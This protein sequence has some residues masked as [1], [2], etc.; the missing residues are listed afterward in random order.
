MTNFSD[1]GSVDGLIGLWDFRS[2]A[3]NKD[4]GLDDGVAQNGHFHGDAYASS[5]QLKLDGHCDYFDVSGNDA[6]FDLSEGTIE[7][8]FQQ[9][10]QVGSSPD[11]LVNRGEYNDK[12][13]EG[14]FA[15]RVTEHGEVLVDHYTKD[16]TV[17]TL[18]TD[19]GLV[20]PHDVINVSYSWDADTGAT[21]TVENL[22]DGTSQTVESDVTGLTMDIGDNDDENFTFGA[23]E[24]DDGKYDQ[25]FDGK[26]DYVAIYDSVQGEGDFIVEGTSGDDLIDVAYTGDPENDSI[27]AGDNQTGGDEDLVDAGAGGDTILSGAA[28]DTV[29][30]GSGA[31]SVEGGVGDDLIYGD[32]SL[33]EA[34][35]TPTTTVR[36]SLEW[37]EETNPNGFTQNTGNV[38]VTFSILNNDPS[39]DAG[40]ESSTQNVAGIDTGGET[41]DATSSFYSEAEY[42][43]DSE[44]Y[45]LDFSEP[46]ENVAFRINDIDGDGVVRVLAYDANN[47]PIEIVLTASANTNL[48][49]SDTDG[50]PGDDTAEGDGDYDNDSAAE[51]SILVEIPGPVSQIVIE[52]S[53][54]GHDDSGINITDV[55]FDAVI[56]GPAETGNDTLIGGDGNDTIFDEYGDNS[57]TSGSEGLPDLG[58]PFL[59]NVDPNPADD[60]DS[61]TTG[62]G[63]DTI[64]T[65]DDNDTIN[66]GNGDNVIDGGFDQDVITSGDGNDFIVGGEGD[67]TITSGGG[68]DTI[69]GGEGEPL[70]NLIDDNVNPI[71]NDPILD[72]G[73]D[74]I[75]AGDGD[76]LVFGE[77]DNDTI[78]GGAGD[79]TLDGGIDD[80]VIDGGSGDDAIVGGQG[81]DTMSGG[82]GDDTFTV[83][84]FTDPIFGDTYLEGLGDSVVGGE[85]ADDGDNDVLD[86]TNAGPLKII[87]DDAIDPTG[88]PGES[89]KVIFYTDASQTEIAGELTFSEIETVI[90]C[91]TP[92]AM[93]ATPHGEVPVETLRQGDKVLTRDNG[94]Q[95]IRW[96]G[97]RTLTRP[98]LLTAPNLR[99][100]LIKAGSLGDGLPERDMLVSPQHRVLA[101]GQATQLYFAE[102]EVLVAAKHLVGMEGI[103]QI[104]TM[105]TTY[106]HFMF[107]RHEV[108]LSDGAWTESFQPGDMTLGS[109]GEAQ[110]DEILALFPELETHVG[111][112]D[113]AA[114]RRTLK[115]H[116]AKLLQL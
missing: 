77:D 7:V 74:L 111:Q 32:S 23:R 17:A 100:I 27:D 84:Q 3:E 52:H 4:T 109:M 72:N 95:E 18:K 40:F 82:T 79:D 25:Y 65:G 43:G 67:D 2:G 24:V 22:T 33:G 69:I 1:P 87:Y 76:D 47:Q 115:A 10:Q 90:P 57:I 55:Y 88:E 60:L 99:P 104:D 46:V 83:G 116:E 41:I 81:A 12:H 30:A 105:R 63:N 114:A 36:E 91:F 59:G 42:S 71:N 101:A 39:V 61:V 107:D 93:I 54:D 50:V 34:P 94:I 26:I 56:E 58:F 86:L 66:A 14:W 113:Y 49:L 19:P 75:D 97:S 92:G 73:D 16:G 8:Q 106:V 78:F 44:T 98:E 53:Q 80:D 31:D 38:D 45:A 11:V 9:D 48:D 108:V 103:Q 20:D 64:N 29:Y 62:N 13:S 96:I 51:Y 70:V 5:D 110:R 35:N 85:D 89:G 112:N 15:I 102:S 37:N 21:L 28:D 68:D 6:P